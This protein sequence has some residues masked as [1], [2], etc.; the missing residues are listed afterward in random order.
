M[1]VAVEPVY[2]YVYELFNYRSG[3]CALGSEEELKGATFK[4][5]Y[6]K[7]N[8]QTQFHF[9]HQEHLESHPSQYPYDHCN[10]KHNFSDNLLPQ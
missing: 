4:F 9:R 8:L 2:I 10:N 7:F 3:R 6:K 1:M 5:N